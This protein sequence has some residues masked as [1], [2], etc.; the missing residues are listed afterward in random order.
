MSASDI[1]IVLSENLLSKLREMTHGDVEWAS[2]KSLCLTLVIVSQPQCLERLQK[3][4]L[5]VQ[6]ADYIKDLLKT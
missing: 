3:L 1:V 6:M 2:G 5:T 4:T